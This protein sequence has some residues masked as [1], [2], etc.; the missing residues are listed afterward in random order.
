[1]RLRWWPVDRPT[2]GRRQ[3]GGGE[4]AN[5]SVAW[6]G[7]SGCSSAGAGTARAVTREQQRK[8]RTEQRLI[9]SGNIKR[10]TQ[11]SKSTGGNTNSNEPREQ[12]YAQDAGAVTSRQRG[13]GKRHRCLP[14]QQ[15]M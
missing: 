15:Q 4:R 6:G 13:K 8:Q 3:D 11:A 14:R 10:A 1:M 9:T 12:Q 7:L 2:P 5:Y